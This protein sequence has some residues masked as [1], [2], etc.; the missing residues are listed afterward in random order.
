[1]NYAKNKKMDSLLIARN[2]YC[3]RNCHSLDWRMATTSSTVWMALSVLLD[4][5]LH[6]RTCISIPRSPIP[7]PKFRQMDLPHHSIP[8]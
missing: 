1:M 3:R 4:P 2:S 5:N 7:D 8:R 6:T